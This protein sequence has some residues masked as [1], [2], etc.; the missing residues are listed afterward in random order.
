MTDT[1]QPRSSKALVVSL[2]VF[3]IVV[4]IIAALFVY[5][6]NESQE[7]VNALSAQ[8]E[9]SEKQIAELVKEGDFVEVTGHE[10]EISK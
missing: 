8:L 10:Q 5:K 7:T 6:W 4:A 9:D 3:L 2:S 1:T